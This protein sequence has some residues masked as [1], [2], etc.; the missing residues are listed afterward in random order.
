MGS[1]E[2]HTMRNFILFT[3]YSQGDSRRLRCA[4]HVT[5]MEEVTRAFKILT[6]KPTGKWHLR[7]PR[8][9]NIRMELENIG[10]N[11]DNWV[12]SA[13]DRYYCECGIEPPSSI[14]HTD[15]TAYH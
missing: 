12:D 6:G 15:I 3:L 10:I 11:A 5:R 13:H 14:N 4:V 7:R 9:N 2:G 1:G 8:E